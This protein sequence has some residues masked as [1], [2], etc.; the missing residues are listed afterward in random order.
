[1]NFWEEWELNPSKEKANQWTE[2]TNGKAY[3]YLRKTMLAKNHATGT[4]NARE[5]NQSYTW[6]ERVIEEDATERENHA[7]QTTHTHH[8]G[9]DFPPHVDNHTDYLR[10]NSRHDD[11]SKEHRHVELGEKHETCRIA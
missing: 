8:V 5:E 7:Y 9:T 10:Y 4:Q 2:K 11:A 6:P 3:E 1:M